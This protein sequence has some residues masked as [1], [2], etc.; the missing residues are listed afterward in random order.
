MSAL[1]PIVFNNAES[2]VSYLRLI[3][4][5]RYFA[6]TILKILVDDQ[7]NIHA[8]RINT[9]RN[10]VTILPGDLVMARTTVQSDNANN[11]KPNFATQCEVSSKLFVVQV[12]VVISFVN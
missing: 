2:V 7:R 4:S 8:E 1:P 3:D 11:K 9:N 12:E 10:I 5:N 6:S